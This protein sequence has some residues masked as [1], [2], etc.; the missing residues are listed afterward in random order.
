MREDHPKPAQAHPAQVQ[1]QD[2]IPGILNDSK[3]FTNADI[4]HNLR[5]AAGILQ[6]NT[7]LVFCG[8]QMKAKPSC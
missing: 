7:G 4:L 2:L 5:K 8:I 1:W 6:Q 3:T